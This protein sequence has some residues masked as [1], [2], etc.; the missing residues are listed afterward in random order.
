LALCRRLIAKYE[1]MGPYLR[2]FSYD[3]Y[4]MRYARGD[5]SVWDPLR[6]GEEEVVDLGFEGV[7]SKNPLPPSEGG[8]PSKEE[9]S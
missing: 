6:N 9:I 1:L 3:E 2:V 4:A 8:A 5:L 7:P